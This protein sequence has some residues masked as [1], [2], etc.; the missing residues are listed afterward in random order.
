MI[1]ELN[2]D[3]KIHYFSALTRCFLLTSLTQALFFKLAKLISDCTPFELEYI[4]EKDFDFSSKNTSM[5][6][7]LYQNGLFDQLE[8]KDGT[9]VYVFSDLAKALKYNSLN[10]DEG[11]NGQER[12]LSIEEMKP[13]SI[14]EPATWHEIEEIIANETLRDS[15]STVFSRD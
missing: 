15:G 14:A 6:S 5:I 13:R 7:L 12:P 1:N 2:D 8:Q 9:T 10:F 3:M 11:L 4:K